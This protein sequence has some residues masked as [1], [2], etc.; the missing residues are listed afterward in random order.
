ML[1]HQP[2][3]KG[4]G[5][6]VEKPAPSAASAQ[7]PASQQPPQRGAGAEPAQTNQLG[8]TLLH[9]GLCPVGAKLRMEP[10]GWAEIA[11]SSPRRGEREPPGAAR[12]LP[13]MPRAELSRE[14]L[15]AAQHS[16]HPFAAGQMWY[17]GMRLLPTQKAAFSSTPDP[18]VPLTNA[19]ESSRAQLCRARSSRGKQAPDPARQQQGSSSGWDPGKRRVSWRAMA[20]VSMHNRC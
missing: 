9:T 10:L 11:L 19:G 16:P 15:P 14:V 4:A 7:A 6:G 17:H 1:S 5:R 2:G 20:T 12:P 13:A 3:G 8:P 18:W